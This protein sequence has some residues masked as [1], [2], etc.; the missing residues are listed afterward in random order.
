[1]ARKATVQDQDAL[2]TN[3][4]ESEE[5]AVRRAANAIDPKARGARKRQLE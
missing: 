4:K 2:E 5:A 3:R 1:M